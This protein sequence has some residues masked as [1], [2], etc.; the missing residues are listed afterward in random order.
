MKM[1]IPAMC[2]NLLID[3]NHKKILKQYNRLNEIIGK[4]GTHS[5]F[6]GAYAVFNRGWIMLFYFV[7]YILLLLNIIY[8]FISE[9]NYY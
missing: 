7:F 8:Y 4:N 2:M 6:W 1:K 9:I 3:K 5:L